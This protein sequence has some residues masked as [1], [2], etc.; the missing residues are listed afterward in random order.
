[1]AKVDFPREA[2]AVADRFVRADI[3]MPET[4]VSRLGLRAEGE[5]EDSARFIDLA[6]AWAQRRRGGRK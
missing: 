3:V 1:M 5:A 2:A 4:I 6:L